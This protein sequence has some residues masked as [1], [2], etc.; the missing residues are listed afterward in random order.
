MSQESAFAYLRH[1]QTPFFRLPSVSCGSPDPGRYRD[2]D[3]VI[4]GVPHDG[5]TTYQPGARLG[6]YHV[7]RTSGL[8][9]SW[10]PA[11]GVDVFAAVRAA[12][13]G[14]VVFPPFDRGAMR[15]A[16]QAEIG[17]IATAGATPF[18]VG[19]DHS[20]ALPV[21][22]A[23]ARVHGPVAVV[24]V[25][26]HLDTS[27]ADTWGDD[28][29]HGTPMRHAI[30]EGL[31]ARG[32][33]HQIGLRG[34]WGGATAGDLAAAHGGVRATAD[35]VASGVAPIAATLRAAIGAR[36]LY[37]SFDIDAIDPAFAPGTG[38]PVP[39]GLTS[40]EALGLIRGLVGCRLV[41]MDLV[42]VA[43]ALDHADLTCHL[44]AHLLFEGLAV[45][46]RR[47]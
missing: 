25:D 44:A 19:G 20:I 6:P 16:V 12:D 24:H 35:D 1:G 22:R 3:A 23:L 9:E 29:H 4:L 17:A 11:L 7:R 15:E 37:I 10:H 21:L 45:R 32:Q 28:F 41:G 33:L 2:L 47:T 36:P 43:P 34:P 18:V 14:N 42:E 30:A 26:A 46:A 5:G 31:I 8:I 38:T 39:G 13:G 27:T 40:R